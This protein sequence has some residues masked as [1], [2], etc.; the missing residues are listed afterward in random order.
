MHV[1]YCVGVVLIL[2][3][4]LTLI[5]SHQRLPRAASAGE[6]SYLSGGWQQLTSIPQPLVL[7]HLGSFVVT[8]LRALCSW[9][10]V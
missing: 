1:N 3:S 5:L 8:P 2:K 7:A 4:R 10:I 6:S 9:I